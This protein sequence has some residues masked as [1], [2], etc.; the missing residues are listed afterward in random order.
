MQAPG[1]AAVGA[2]V[3]AVD[4]KTHTDSGS[5]P[6]SRPLLSSSRS[7]LV[8]LIVML[9]FFLTVVLSPK[10]PLAR[11]THHG[12]HRH[13]QCQRCRCRRRAIV[14][15]FIVVFISPP[16]LSSPLPLPPQV[17]FK[18]RKEG[19]IGDGA[20]GRGMINV[21]KTWR[22]GSSSSSSLSN[23]NNRPPRRRPRTAVAKAGRRAVGGEG[24]GA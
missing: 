24:G 16:F 2:S 21:D 11:L 7:L 20:G 10:R 3:G 19:D 4:P 6:T 5:G 15:V 1:F 18:R 14:F 9:I 13:C 8:F 12:S 22:R 23:D 17:D